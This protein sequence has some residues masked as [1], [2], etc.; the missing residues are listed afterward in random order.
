MD[1]RLLLKTWPQVSV[2]LAC[3]PGRLSRMRRNSVLSRGWAICF[4]LRAKTSW[5]WMASPFLLTR[6]T[7]STRLQSSKLLISTRA[8]SPTGRKL[9]AIPDRSI[10]TR[11]TRTPERLTP[12]NHSCSA[13]ERCLPEHHV[14]RI[15]RNF[16][17]QWR[18]TRME[19]GWLESHSCVEPN[20]WPY[21]RLVQSRCY[22][23]RLLLRLETICSPAVCSS[24][25]PLTR[26]TNGPASSWSLH[27]QDWRSFPGGP[28]AAR[29]P[30]LRRYSKITRNGN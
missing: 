14:T 13:P 21:L 27:V 5:A 3:P 16:R 1:R 28:P 25:S 9:A 19:S 20:R 23:R 18:P 8:K 6:A 4:R 30:R 11:P 29:L 22:R 7:R 26:K 12:L 10:S 2:T 17:T 15:A 24:T